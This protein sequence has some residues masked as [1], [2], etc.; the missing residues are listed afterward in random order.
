M[1]GRRILKIQSKYETGSAVL[2][3]LKTKENKAMHKT[4]KLGLTNL[5]TFS[6][7]KLGGNIPQLNMPV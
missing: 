3:K 6:N 1:T 2:Y 5:V 4:K 7:I